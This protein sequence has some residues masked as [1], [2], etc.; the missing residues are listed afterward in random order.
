MAD[1]G[2]LKSLSRSFG[3]VG[4]TPT[5][6]TFISLESRRYCE[7]VGWGCGAGLVAVG[8]SSR[9]RAPRWWARARWKQ[10]RLTATVLE[11]RQK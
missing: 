5:P 3:S 2:D 9:S 1:A 10:P 8:L 7:C 6:G 11:F 4:S